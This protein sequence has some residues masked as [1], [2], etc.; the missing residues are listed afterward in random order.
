MSLMGAHSPTPEYQNVWFLDTGASNHMC[1]RKHMFVELDETVNGQVSFGDLSKVPV[2]GRGN[3]LIK[4]KNGDHDYIS[5]VFYVP[6][7]KNNILSLGQLLEKGYDIRMKD[8]HLTIL[9]GGGNQIA[10]VKMLK[11]RMFVLNIQHDTA[12]CLN[13]VISDKDWLWHLRFG[14][15]NFDSLKLLASKNMVKGLPHIN[16]PNEVCESCVL[17]KHHRTN[18]GKQVD[19]RAKQPLELVHTDVCGPLT[20]MSNGKNKYFLTFI[21]DYSR[22]T[23]VYF[24]K[25]KSEVFEVFKEFKALVERQSGYQIQTLRSDQGGEYTSNAF[26]S[27]CKNHGIKHQ[28]TPS[29][30]PQL[31]GVAER[32]NRTILDMAR[33]MLKNKKLP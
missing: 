9:D 2:K 29:Y 18:F 17:G 23:W 6:D 15:L 14:H 22:K 25:Q 12:K 11:N 26:E 8:S 3:I 21:D 20:P 1:G 5:N 16:R 13:A 32:K 7:M 19:W 28:V 33:S 24:L 4:L 30:T 27:Y 10:R 31:N